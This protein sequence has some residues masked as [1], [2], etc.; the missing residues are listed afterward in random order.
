RVSDTERS[1]TVISSTTVATTVRPDQADEP[2]S[3]LMVSAS[4]TPR[5]HYFQGMEPLGDMSDEERRE[6]F[7]K[8]GNFFIE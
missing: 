7:I 1:S 3:I 4:G 6:W 8:N 2:T 5:E